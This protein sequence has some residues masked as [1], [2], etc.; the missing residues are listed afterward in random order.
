M[1]DEQILTT[2]K[3]MLFGSANGMFRDDMLNAYIVEVENFMLNA[4]VKINVIRSTS[5]VGVIALG[6]NDLWN[7]QAGGVKLSE[8]FRQRV[9]QLAYTDETEPTPTKTVIQQFT[10]RIVT[11]EQSTTQVVFDLPDYDK[12]TDTINVYTNG[13]IEAP[14]TDY[15]IAGNVI[16]F[17]HAK[18]A[19]TE[20]LVVVCKLVAKE[21]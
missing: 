8:Y 5:S 9:T 11:S 2:V 13:M 14:G 3:T 4:G 6:V 12:D 15:T 16:T 17:E 21:T 1:T 7:Y 18:I 10:Q 19:Q 20:I